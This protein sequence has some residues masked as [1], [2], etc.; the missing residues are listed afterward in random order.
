MDVLTEDVDAYG[1]MSGR[2]ALRIADQVQQLLVEHGPSGVLV[3]LAR[4]HDRHSATHPDD[5]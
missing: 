1:P 3:T 4:F 2:I 5:P